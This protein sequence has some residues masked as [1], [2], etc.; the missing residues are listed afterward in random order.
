[1]NRLETIEKVRQSRAEWDALVATVPEDAWEINAWE[2]GWNLRDITAHVQF[3]EWWTG[4]FIRKGDW[5]EVDA[6]LDT[7]DQDARNDALYEL[8]KDRSTADVRSDAPRSV[9]GLIDALERMTDEQYAEPL[10]T[11]PNGDEWT[12]ESMVASGSW[13]HYPMH[14]ADVESIRVKG[15]G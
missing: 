2:N 15:E 3:Y 6:S 5:P 9:A 1:M 7:F 14:V 11:L 12:A 4:E 13:N 10:L 8:N